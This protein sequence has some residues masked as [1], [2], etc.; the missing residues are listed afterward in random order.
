MI[1][2]TNLHAI[3]Q[4]DADG[5][6]ALV[7]R[8]TGTNYFATDVPFFSI[9]KAGE[10]S[11]A[12]ALSCEGEQLTVD[13]PGV[14]AVL[15]V[16]EE[17]RHF[18]FEVVEVQGDV[19]QLTFLDLRLDLPG[20]LDE[21]FIACALALNLQTNVP[22]LPGPMKRPRA[23]CYAR[24]GLV[25]AKAALIACPPGEMRGIM[26]E[27][28]SAAPELPHSPLG[29]P[30]ALDAPL[31]RG[32][33]LFNFTDCTEETVDEWITL[34]KSIGFTQLDFH[35]SQSFRFGDCKPNPALYPE[36]RKSLKRVIDRLHD[37]GI[38]A[39]LHT[40]AFFIDKACPWVTPVPDPRLGSD[41]VFTMAAPL[42]ADATE[43]PVLEST[44]GMSTI[45][46]FFVRNS[47]TFR[48][49]EELITYSGIAPGAFTGCTRGACG[50]KPAAHAAGAKAYHLKE[51]FGLFTPDGDNS[52]LEE[53]AAATARTFNE[54]GFDMMYLDALDGEDI[55]GG[56]EWG[57]HYGS[58]FVFEIWQRI[59]RPALQEMST[60]HHHLW[61]VRSR[62]GAWDHPNRG[63]KPFIDIHAACNARDA[64]MFLPAH[65]GWW[66]STPFTDQQNERTFPDV[67]EYLCAKAAGTDTGFALMGLTPASL[68]SPE[69]QRAAGILRRWE[70]LRH[71][72]TLSEEMKVRLREPGA[73]FTLRDDGSICPVS[74]LKHKIEGSTA[75]WIVDNPFDGQPPRIRIEALFSAEPYEAGEVITDF[76][77]VSLFTERGTAKGV[78]GELIPS[79]LRPGAGRFTARNDGTRPNAAWAKMRRYFT[80]PLDLH[81]HQGLGVWVH[82]DGQGE[83]L[84]V[85]LRSP[86]HVSNALG[87]H[88][89]IIDFIGWRYFE[90]IEPEGD[91]YGD[92]RWPYAIPEN[93]WS[94]PPGDEEGTEALHWY[95]GGYHVYR[96]RVHYDQVECIALYLNNIPEGEEATVHIGPI[97]ALPL[98]KG[99]LTRPTLSI[100]DGTVT[101][102]VTLETGQYLELEGDGAHTVYGPDGAVV[103]TD[104]LQG[105]IPPL[106]SGQNEIGLICEQRMGYTPRAQVTLIVQGEPIY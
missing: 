53:V 100:N 77:D 42:D 11:P 10:S 14:R 52:L 40:Y 79:D 85:Q 54:C 45:T 4:I 57:W 83:V 19:E 22:D 30:W 92:Y 82:G 21:A 90:L 32:S 105:A 50:T 61:Y 15:R 6:C 17:E 16:T 62:F 63:H 94:P 26:Q 86:L 106:N 64:K 49:D 55:L 43:L 78:T 5:F 51:C 20:T 88:Y 35:G 68:A 9:M 67:H 76:T 74:Y 98:K 37:A 29:G 75:R 1:E 27:V 25:G 97:K 84:N 12:T 93:A 2:L 59:D 71:A 66:A 95:M 70:N 60:F 41:A 99:L 18:L 87:E 72:G 23:M 8:K 38:A 91:R 101:L 81:E 104:R 7:D 24:T 69:L 96:E 46:G 31:N 48:I 34:V 58:K 39:G 13:F 36:G 65:L 89:I 44:D 80:P 3:L 33:Y 47:V 73:E 56:Q 102:P 103:L 28:V